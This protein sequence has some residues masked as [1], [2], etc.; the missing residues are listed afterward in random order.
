M[1]QQIKKI[2]DAKNLNI[3]DR[4]RKFLDGM[5][6]KLENLQKLTKRQKGYVNGLI[7]KYRG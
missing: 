5:R 2:L 4:D 1:K 3:P 7:K 6:I